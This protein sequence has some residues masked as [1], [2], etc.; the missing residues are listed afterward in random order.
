[1]SDANQ[2]QKYYF[3]D[4]YIKTQI[5]WPEKENKKVIVVKALDQQNDDNTYVVADLYYPYSMY[6]KASD[7]IYEDFI[8]QLQSVDSNLVQK[9]IDHEIITEEDSIHVNVLLPFYIFFQRNNH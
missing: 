4:T 9:P 3:N 8:A 5:L 6:P 7:D 1:M 2:T